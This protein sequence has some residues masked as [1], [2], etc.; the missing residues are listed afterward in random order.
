M[1]IKMLTKRYST[2]MYAKILGVILFPAAF[3]LMLVL[4]V[5][6]LIPQDQYLNVF[7]N[8]CVA[9]G[10]YD[11]TQYTMYTMMPNDYHND[12]IMIAFI[13]VA[14]LCVVC[15]IFL[16]FANR[17]KMAAAPASIIL[18]EVIFSIFRS[19]YKLYEATNFF[20]AYKPEYADGANG[21]VHQYKAGDEFSIFS[22]FAQY[23]VLWIAAI[24]LLAGVIVAIASTKTLIEK[25]K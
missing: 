3:I 1:D 23:W 16:L 9:K 15:G 6:E 18:A 4:P 25:K 10:A 17:P 14:A 8:Q 7:N 5:F 19:P 2:P 21:F 24:V 12:G 11:S 13:I 22:C 20:K